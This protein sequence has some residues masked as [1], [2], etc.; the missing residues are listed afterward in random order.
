MAVPTTRN[1]KV[2]SNDKSPYYMKYFDKSPAK[3]NDNAIM[4]FTAAVNLYSVIHSRQNT[5]NIAVIMASRN[6]FTDQSMVFVY[7]DAFFEFAIH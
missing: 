4:P 3:C 5:S 1:A 2:P 7:A 6:F